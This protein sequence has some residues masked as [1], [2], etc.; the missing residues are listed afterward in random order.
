[1]SLRPVKDADRCRDV[2]LDL[3]Q[4]RTLIAKAPAD[5]VVFLSALSLVP[6]RPGAMAALVARKV[7]KRLST[8]GGVGVRR[9]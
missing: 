2:Y 3:S 4:R 9:G 7:D 1:M 8:C 6:P 5:L